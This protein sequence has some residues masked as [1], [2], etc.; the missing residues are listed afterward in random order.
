MFTVGMVECGFREAIEALTRSSA[1][2]DESTGQREEFACLMDHARELS[3]LAQQLT[4]KLVRTL[5]EEH[6]FRPD[7][8]TSF[9]ELLHRGRFERRELKDVTRLASELFEQPAGLERTEPRPPR[10]PKTALGFAEAKFGVASAME[11]SKVLD[12]IP[13]A[14]PAATVFRVESMLADMAE[15]LAPEDLRKAG[16]KILQGL[17]AESEPKDEDRQRRRNVTVTAQRADLMSGIKGEITPELKALL[18]RL[19]AD[20]AGPGDL[21]PEKEKAD[22]TR[23]AAQRR[24]DAL[25]AALKAAL[26]REGPMPPTRGCSTV[27]ATLGLDQLQRA[28][29]VVPTDVGTLL[30]V[31]DLI[32]L[33]ADRNAFLAILDPETGN[34]IELGRTKRAADIYAYLGLVASQGGDQT[35][36]SDL[37]AALCE[38]HHVHPWAEGGETV[39]NN[40]MLVGHRVHRNIDDK[41]A[42]RKKYWTICTS[43]GHLL[44]RLPDTIDPKRE[45]RA[46]FNPAQ[47]FIPGQIMRW[48][49]GPPA[50]EPPFQYHRCRDCGSRV[51]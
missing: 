7:S 17:N 22:D 40:L 3:W 30:P 8:R 19:F 49:L 2:L 34:L 13:E 26:H 27:V 9:N 1:M 20:Y 31:R 25:T 12:Q 4:V 51:A 42:N 45:L 15:W 14:T 41:K 29:G 36:G 10:L 43:T 33:G 21:L 5:A 16:I 23:T 46:N 35:P 32:R 38:I 28:A 37:P 39:G 18:D 50:E 48:G 47:W 11:I 24:H 6:F 44:W